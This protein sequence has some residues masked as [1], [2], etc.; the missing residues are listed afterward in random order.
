MEKEKEEQKKKKKKKGS[1]K[2]KDISHVFGTVSEEVL[3]PQ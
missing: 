3:P 2:D 1:A